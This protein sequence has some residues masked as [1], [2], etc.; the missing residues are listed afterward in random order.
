MTRAEFEGRYADG[1]LKMAFIGM[2][3]IGKS[4]TALR[5]ATHYDYKLIEVDKITIIMSSIFRPCLTILND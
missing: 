3:N 4:Y 2:S 1:A 5:L